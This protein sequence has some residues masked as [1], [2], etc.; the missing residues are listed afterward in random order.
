MI[1]T[2]LLTGDD[3][4]KSLGTRL[5]IHFLKDKYQLAVTGT[6]TQQSG[7]GGKLSLANG[8]HWGEDEVDGVKALWVDGTP[9]DAIELA[10]NYFPEQFDLTISGINWG[11]NLGPGV[12]GS[13]TL[14]AALRAASTGLSRETVAMSWDL[15][16]GFYLLDHDDNLPLD[17]YL[18]Y[19]GE[20]ILTLLDLLIHHNFFNAQL[21]NINFPKEPS[22]Q[23]AIT[24]LMTNLREVYDYSDYDLTKTP[25]HFLYTGTRLFNDKLDDNYDVK[26]ITNGF[27]SVSPCTCELTDHS[28]FSAATG[29]ALGKKLA[30]SSL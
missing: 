29:K 24:R 5:L 16:T 14:N 8:F 10:A 6:R 22:H 17:N 2:I 30:L 28:T 20:T 7:V 1:K 18:L 27:I 21:L 12:F 3:G 26:A 11:A 19:P 15:P 9:V 13:G 4:Y 25:G 23:V